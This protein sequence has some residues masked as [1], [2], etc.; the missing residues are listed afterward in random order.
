[1]A[2][3]FEKKSI[4]ERLIFLMTSIVLRAHTQTSSFEIALGDGAFFSDIFPVGIIFSVKVSLT[5]FDKSSV[6]AAHTDLLVAQDV[7]TRGRSDLC[8]GF[9]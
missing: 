3:V 4:I 9:L 8:S 1:L 6:G 2:L 5:G 7:R